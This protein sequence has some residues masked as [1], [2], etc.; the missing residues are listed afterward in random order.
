MGTS[1]GEGPKKKFGPILGGLTPSIMNQKQPVPLSID[2][3]AS[4]FK[5]FETGY[6][7]DGIVGASCAI[8]KP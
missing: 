8:Q 4:T 6:L 7:T 1:G 5:V 3:S 2:Q